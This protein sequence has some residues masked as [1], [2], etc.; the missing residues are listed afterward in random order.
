MDIPST[1]PTIGCAGE[2]KQPLVPKV[3]IWIKPHNLSPVKDNQKLVDFF[4]NPQKMK[5]AHDSYLNHIE[6]YTVYEIVGGKKIKLADTHKEY[7][8]R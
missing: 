4:S 3:G 7:L 1:K 2:P 5:K 6:N 8:N